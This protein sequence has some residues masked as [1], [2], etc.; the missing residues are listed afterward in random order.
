MAQAQAAQSPANAYRI[1]RAD[2]PGVPWARYRL[3]CAW[4]SSFWS[5][6]S[7]S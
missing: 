6:W 3:E 2:R 5:G 1:G 7:L 4:S